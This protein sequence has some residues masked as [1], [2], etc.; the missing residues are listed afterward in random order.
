MMPLYCL[1]ELV[2]PAVQL[3][4]HSLSGETVD[5]AMSSDLMR[6]RLK[7]NSANRRRFLVLTS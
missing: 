4:A 1:I 7:L 6:I 5:C 3:F 2:F